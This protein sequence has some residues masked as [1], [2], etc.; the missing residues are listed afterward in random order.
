MEDIFFEEDEVGAAAEL[1]FSYVMFS[2]GG[3]GLGG[4]GDEGLARGKVFLSF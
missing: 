2:E 1:D 4:V 3:S